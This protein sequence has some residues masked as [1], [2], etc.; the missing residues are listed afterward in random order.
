MAVGF[1]NGDHHGRTYSRLAGHS[2]RD[3]PSPGHSGSAGSVTMAEAIPMRR[4]EVEN[5]LWF[6][7]LWIVG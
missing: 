1:G 4:K 2:D 5:K 6:H 3:D 7:R